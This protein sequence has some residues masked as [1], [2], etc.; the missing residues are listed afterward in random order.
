MLIASHNSINNCK[1]NLHLKFLRNIIL[2][3]TLL[4]LFSSFSFSQSY[5][6][7]SNINPYH[8]LSKELFN[9]R[10]VM[11]GDYDHD[12]PGVYQHVYDSYFGEGKSIYV[13]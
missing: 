5:D 12:Q 4:L 1:Y 7:L 3:L 2:T 9:H 6:S 10:I 11:F 13:A 8:H